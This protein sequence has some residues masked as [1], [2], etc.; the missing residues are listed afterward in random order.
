MKQILHIFLKDTRHLWI[1]I[2]ISL[3]LTAALVIT[4][5][6]SWF[7]G[8][9]SG[10][11][12]S[13]S[14]RASLMFLPSLLTILVPISW[15]IVISPLIHEERLVGDR[16]FWLTRPYEWKLLLAAKVSFLFV[17][18][19]V[20][21]FIAQCLI[22][23]VAGFN[24]LSYLPGLLYNLLLITVVLILP[25]V[26]LATVTRNFARMTLVVL[27]LLLSLVVCAW[28]T[29][30]FPGTHITTPFGDALSLALVICGCI[31]VV[32][33]QY[34]LRRSTTAWV[35]LSATLAIIAALACAAPD[36]ALMSHRYPVAAGSAQ[37]IELSYRND[38]DGGPVAFAGGAQN[39]QIWVPI[40]VLG[41]ATGSMMF[42]QDLKATLDAPDG[43]HWTSFWEPVY[44]DKFMPGERTARASFA[45]PRSLYDK[46]KPLPLRLH[47]VLAIER[48]RAAE[49]F[50][51][52]MPLDNFRIPGF[53]RCTPATGFSYKPYEIGGIFCRAAMREPPLTLVHV[54]WS[55][56]D[57]LVP[58][59]QRRDVQGQA[60]TGSL[61]RPP[62]D[63][64][65]NPV[66]GQSIAFMDNVD[67]PHVNEPRHICSGTPASFTPYQPAGR[68]Q[69]SLDIQG[70]R[71]PE[72]SLGQMRV[73][74]RHH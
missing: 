74:L 16:Q 70:F 69:T 10:V 41:I 27:G 19:F 65:I 36:Q 22:L 52:S 12:V 31:A 20:P 50:T 55:Y 67:D 1:E 14:P 72:L 63:F 43:T 33:V 51:I 25:L 32:V 37:E 11:T 47:I 62:A 54:V 29:S 60:W 44:M 18:V 68:M 17:F 57:C 45:I 2:L 35:L 46:L 4:S 7:T 40:H 5:P 59:E 39:V 64:A 53:A 28:L 49:T 24:P 8:F 61:D 21:I 42:P 71:L 73:I 66:W 38:A 15:W 23:V 34:A 48:A 58:V 26:T 13:Y 30:Q 3:G 56:D 6:R 9:G